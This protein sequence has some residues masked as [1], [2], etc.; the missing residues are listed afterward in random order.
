MPTSSAP[1]RRSLRC[2]GLS[3]PSRSPCLPLVDPAVAVEQV[4]QAEQGVADGPQVQ[5]VVQA[6]AVVR[7]ADHLSSNR[8]SARTVPQRPLRL[9]LSGRGGRVISRPGPGLI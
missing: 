4:E 9:Y 1:T 2:L 3:L 7:A 5:A 8:I 6:V